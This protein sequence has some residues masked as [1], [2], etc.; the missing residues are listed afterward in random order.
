MS[1][2]DRFFQKVDKTESCW[3]WTGAL[4]SRGYGAIGIN[5]KSVSAHRYSY[6]I[7]KDKIPEGMFVCHSCDVPRCVNP[8]HLW[9]GTNKD[10][11]RDMIKKDR[12]GHTARR[13]THCQSGHSLDGDGSIYRDRGNGR[14]DRTCRECKKINDSKRHGTKN[15]YLRAYYQK[16]REELNRKAREKYHKEKKNKN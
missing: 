2:E 10:N 11:M 3:L 16:N 15:E 5:G 13:R 14:I 8:D 9:L 1:H 7:H 12:Q 6:E 4:N